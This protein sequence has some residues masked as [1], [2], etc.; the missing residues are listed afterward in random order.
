MIERPVPTRIGRRL[1]VVRIQMAQRKSDMQSF[2]CR[3]NISRYRNLL[4]FTP[5]EMQRREIKRLLAAEETTLKQLI[6]D[7]ADAP[8]KPRSEK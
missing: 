5:G 1:C 3:Q 2:V 8:L 6:L 4:E 7:E